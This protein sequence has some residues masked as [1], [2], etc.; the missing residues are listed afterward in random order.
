MAKICCRR[1]VN[2]LFKKALFCRLLF[3][4]TVLIG[5]ASILAAL[6]WSVFFGLAALIAAP[7]AAVL[8]RRR[9]VLSAGAVG[10]KSG[11]S[12]LRKL[13]DCFTLFPDITL[14]LDDKTAQLDCLVLGPTGVFVV[15]IKNHGGTLVGDLQKPELKK[16]RFLPNGKVKQSVIYNPVFQVRT[17][18]RLLRALLTQKSFHPPVSG[19]VYIANSHTVLNLTGSSDLPIF[20]ARYHG[21]AELLRF[22]SHG[23]PVLSE[24]QLRSLKRFLF[25][26]CS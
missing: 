20:A 1:R 21:D 22:L 11:L 9:R 19:A 24:T 4:I 13:P 18:C 12:V 6:V 7:V 10:E 25:A 23:K 2:S 17:H 3:F 16:L 26:H 8:N 5:A 15:E 14:H